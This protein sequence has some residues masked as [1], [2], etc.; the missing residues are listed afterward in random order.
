VATESISVS[1][2]VPARPSRGYAGWLD[3]ADRAAM[4]GAARRRRASA[5]AGGAQPA[6]DEPRRGAR[7]ARKPGVRAEAPLT[8]ARGASTG[9]RGG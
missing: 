1:R 9:E 6:R 2:V 7:P 5:A 8:L 4:T 3:P